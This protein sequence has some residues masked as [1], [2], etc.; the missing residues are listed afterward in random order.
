[1]ADMDIQRAGPVTGIVRLE[2]TR[3]PDLDPVTFA[4]IDGDRYHQVQNDAELGD[5]LVLWPEDATWKPMACAL[6]WVLQQAAGYMTGD[7]SGVTREGA[8]L[9]AR[10]VK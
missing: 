1:M 3:H 8:A 6:R 4:T 9:P 10:E 5:D 7:M 2:K